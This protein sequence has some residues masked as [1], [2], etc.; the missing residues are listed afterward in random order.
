MKGRITIKTFLKV[1]VAIVTILVVSLPFLINHFSKPKIEEISN[2]NSSVKGDSLKYPVNAQGETY[3]TVHTDGSGKIITS[4]DLIETKGENGV[5]GYV[6]EKDL[7]PRFTSPEEALAHQKA[8][9]IAGYKSIPLYKSDG[10]TI[11]GEFKLGS[12]N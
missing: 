7:N 6:K 10:K 1:A 4:P 5:L 8:V 3:G 11:I 12:E 9:D 2:S